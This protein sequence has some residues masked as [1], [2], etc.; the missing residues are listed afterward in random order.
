M[1]FWDSM[2]LATCPSNGSCEYLDT[3]G[4]QYTCYQ[5]HAMLKL[6]EYSN[7]PTRYKVDTKLKPHPKDREE[8]KWLADYKN[9]IKY[10]IENGHGLYLWSPEK[11]NGKTTWASKL[12]LA[13]FNEIALEFDMTRSRGLY[14]NVPTFIED[15]KESWDDKNL[16]QEMTIL[17]DRIR[18]A[19]VVIWDDIGT[20][21]PKEWILQLLYSFIN[22]RYSN[23]LTQI[24]TS[25]CDLVDLAE[26]FKDNRITDRIYE[27]C[28]PIR[29]YGGSR[30]EQD[31]W[32]NTK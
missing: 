22:Y 23:K 32:W 9:D 31:A 7:L 17:K 24:F 12:M 16:N 2:G 21:V 5:Y 19:D 30:R 11:G 25:N 1:S 29:F 20:E 6:L 26:Q 4:C 8:F 10:H 3:E 27:M 28:K 18:R 13:Y 14:I 15:V